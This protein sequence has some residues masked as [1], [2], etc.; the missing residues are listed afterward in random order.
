VNGVIEVQQD[1]EIQYCVHS[2]QSKLFNIHIFC[3]L[4]ETCQYD[5]HIIYILQ[6]VNSLTYSCVFIGYKDITTNICCFISREISNVPVSKPF[7]MS[8]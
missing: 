3:V 7:L 1:A 8:I 2:I 5:L 6:T 4:T